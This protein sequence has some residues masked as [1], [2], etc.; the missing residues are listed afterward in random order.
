MIQEFMTLPGHLYGAIPGVLLS[1]PSHRFVGRIYDSKVHAVLDLAAVVIQASVAG[2]F[3]WIKA[4][5]HAPSAMVE[6]LGS[7][8]IAIACFSL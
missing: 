7:A 5:Q 1:F 8:G 3:S 4:K 6:S 2:I